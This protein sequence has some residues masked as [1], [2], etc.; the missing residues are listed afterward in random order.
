MASPIPALPSIRPGRNRMIG[1]K[2][3]CLRSGSVTKVQQLAN[4][5]ANRGPAFS[6]ISS[7][8][9]V[10]LDE[11]PARSTTIPTRCNPDRLSSRPS[12]IP[13][14]HPHI[15][16]AVPAPVA[17][18]P[19]LAP[20]SVWRQHRYVLTA[21][22]RWLHSDDGDVTFNRS[23]NTRAEQHRARTK[24]DATPQEPAAG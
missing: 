4:A 16:A 5:L 11:D 3:R 6:W 19:I 18:L 23:D 9:P 14:V 20:R 7:S 2:A 17:R 15:F 10:A 8:G 1:G 12:R 13:A 21:R 22:W 24:H